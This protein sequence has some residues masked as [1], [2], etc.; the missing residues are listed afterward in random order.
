M[1]VVTE[2]MLNAYN[3]IIVREAM[4]NVAGAM[5]NEAEYILNGI[6]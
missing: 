3:M 1:L 6:E 5:Q 2:A 4:L